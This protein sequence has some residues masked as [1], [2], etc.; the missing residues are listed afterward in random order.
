MS[1][2]EVI[3]TLNQSTGSLSVASVAAR[4]DVSKDWV[5]D[6]IDQF[7]NAWRLPTEVS[8]SHNVGGLRIPVADLV[9]FQERR[10]V[11]QHK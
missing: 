2:E 3:E 5:R 9:S 11:F 1:I 10:R 4:L 7:P 6:H 8:G